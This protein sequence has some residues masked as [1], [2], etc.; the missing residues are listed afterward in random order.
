MKK[1]LYYA[2]SSLALILALGLPARADRA[3]AFSNAQANVPGG[4]R[5]MQLPSICRVNKSLTCVVCSAAGKQGI[6][7]SIEV[8]S[9]VVGNFSVA[10][11][12]GAIPANTT[13]PASTGAGQLLTWQKTCEAT[14]A[15]V[16]TNK[17]TCGFKRFEDGVPYSNGLTLC[18]NSADLNTVALFYET[19]TP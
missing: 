6:L 2:F 1:T 3:T 19:R 17:G 4:A 13:Q 10:L 5:K 14:Q 12:T 11:D 18:S 7:V 9:G 8:S 16:D 15:T